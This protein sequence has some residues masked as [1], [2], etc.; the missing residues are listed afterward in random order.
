MQK[1]PRQV[2]DELD[3]GN[4]G[5]TLLVMNKTFNI[6]IAG[7]YKRAPPKDGRIV[8]VTGWK[9]FCEQPGILKNKAM[10]MQFFKK[11]DDLVIV[12]TLL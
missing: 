12:T 4:E 9:A 6:E 1:I 7:T 10:M 2:A 3:V 8:L 11:N 5:I